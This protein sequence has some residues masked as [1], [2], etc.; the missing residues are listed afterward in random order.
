[1]SLQ[2]L[3]SRKFYEKL[4]R[5]VK[6]IAKDKPSA[7]VKFRKNVLQEI[8]KIPDRMRSHKKCDFFD[9]QNIRELIYKGY[10]IVFEIRENEIV[11]FGFHK[12]EDELR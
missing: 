12:W 1:M 2:L 7:A 5:Q 6:Y 11:V 4:N 8:T 3:I 10:R 9:D